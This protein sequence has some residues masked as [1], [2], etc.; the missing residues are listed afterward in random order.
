MSITLPA[1]TRRQ[2]ARQFVAF[3]RRSLGMAAAALILTGGLTA[4][5]VPIEISYITA[6][7]RCYAP[8]QIYGDGFAPGKV[9][10]L[11]ASPAMDIPPEEMIKSIDKANI[12]TPPTPPTNARPMEVISLTPQV[13]TVKALAGSGIGWEQKY[14]P[15]VVWTRNADGFSR[16]FVINRPQLYFL[17]QATAAPGQRLRFFGRDLVAD[18][19]PN[20]STIKA[21]VFL[22]DA[23]S[24]RVFEARWGKYYDQQNHT[25]YQLRFEILFEVPADTPDGEYQLWLHSGAGGWLGWCRAPLTLSVRRPAPPQKVFH[26]GKFGAVGDGVADDTVALQSAIEAAR[27]AGGGLVK[28]PAGVFAISSPLLLPSGVNLA[29]LGMERTSIQVVDHLPFSGEYRESTYTGYALDFQPYERK[30]KLLPMIW[31]YSKSSISDLELK[32]GHSVAY[33]MYTMVEGDGDFH[34]FTVDK[35]R[36]INTVSAFFTNETLGYQPPKGGV[37]AGVSIWRRI[38]ITNNM[39]RAVGLGST[40]SEMTLGVISG[41][42]FEPPC[43]S[44]GTTG[45]CSIGGWRNLIENNIIRN[46]N[47]GMGGGPWGMQNQGENIIARNEVVNGGPNKG[48]AESFLVEFA[49]GAHDTWAGR[50]GQAGPDW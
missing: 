29:G 25:N 45:F 26:A 42:D 7:V 31:V 8:I 12:S 2:S 13:A 21:H 14:A 27:K 18:D 38:R 41:N 17:E 20:P 46:S 28:L 37:I 9:E 22:R 36:L 49:G 23:A 43:R 39:I 19:A 6:S 24:G 30:A 50:V 15:V 10:F 3:Y 5:S 11:A 44:F 35:C 1:S 47:R 40:H 16:P 34:D 4:R 48:A 33:L 32:A